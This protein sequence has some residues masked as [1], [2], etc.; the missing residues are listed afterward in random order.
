MGIW[1]VIR[2]EKQRTSFGLANIHTDT[3]KQNCLGEGNF[4]ITKKKF[5][6]EK[7]R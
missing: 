7:K 1:G 6:N 5:R 3:H 2:V 4:K